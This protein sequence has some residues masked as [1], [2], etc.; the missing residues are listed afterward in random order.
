MKHLDTME[1][2]GYPFDD[3]S[4]DYL[5]QMHNDRDGFLHSVFGD[6]KIVKGVILNISSNLYSD[7][8]ITIGGKLYHFV[9]GAP[10]ATISKKVVA[11][12]RQYEDGLEKKAF[13]NEFYEFG[14]A[15]TDVINFEDLKRWYQNQPIFKEL[16]EVAGDITN[17]DLTGT[18]WFIAD[19]TNGTDDLRSL[20]IVAKD[21]RDTDY[22]TVGKTGGEKKHQLSA[23]E[24]PK[25]T[26]SVYVGENGTGYPDG[27]G[28][29][30]AAGQDHSYPRKSKQLKTGDFGANNQPHENR[31]PY[32]VAIRIQFLGI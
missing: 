10:E 15:G 21:T 30:L 25:A 24:L 12:K 20:F 4:I 11:T 3:I 29:S 14:S 26:S 13:V 9:G 27:A 18:G 1:Q 23:A 17:S 5:Q 6:L 22:D 32:Y 19:G 31:P 28:E 16:K 2:G 8:L 7:G